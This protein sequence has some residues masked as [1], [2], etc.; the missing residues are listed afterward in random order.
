MAA[1]V[2]GRLASTLTADVDAH[3]GMDENYSGED[4][5][6]L[7]PTLDVCPDSESG[8]LVGWNL[9]ALDLFHLAD[10]ALDEWVGEGGKDA[11][12]RGKATWHACFYAAF[13]PLP[14]LPEEEMAA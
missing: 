6:P 8:G 2:A 9:L 14:P 4:R 1:V 3:G 7:A 10:A 11:D 12:W 5:S 13:S